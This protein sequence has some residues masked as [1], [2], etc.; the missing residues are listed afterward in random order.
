M[1]YAEGASYAQP[2]TGNVSSM[3]D[4]MHGVADRADH[5]SGHAIHARTW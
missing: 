3:R 2:F 4:G 5:F 1:P